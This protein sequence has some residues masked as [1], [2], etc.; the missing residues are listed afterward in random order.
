MQKID[1]LTKSRRRA[2]LCFLLASAV[3]SSTAQ[4]GERHEHDNPIVLNGQ[5][6][7]AGFDGGVG[8]RFDGGVG[9]RF[10]GDD[11]GYGYGQ[12][13]INGGG[14]S[15]FARTNAFL[16]AA[17]GRAFGFRRGGHFGGGMHMGGGMHGGGGRH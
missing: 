1:R 10:G 14:P 13:Y 7:L 16:S 6:S 9:D 12:P 2:M 8:D 15:A 3:L 5:L 17:L 4:A 11:G